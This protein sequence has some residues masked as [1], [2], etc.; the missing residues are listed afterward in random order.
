MQVR[1]EADYGSEEQNAESRNY[2]LK[3][4]RDG[5]ASAADILIG[6][7]GEVSAESKD[8]IESARK[9]YD[10][11]TEEQKASVKN[12]GLLSAAEIDYVKVLI[13]AIGT[14]HGN[15]RKDINKA[16]E[17]YN[18]LLPEQQT[19]VQSSDGGRHSSV[20]SS[21]NRL[22]RCREGTNLLCWGRGVPYYNG[23]YK[24]RGGNLFLPME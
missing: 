13:D 10:A 18:A 9:A 15:S 17:A 11:L 23:A 14:V 21:N 19:G 12:Y 2:I 22:P 5:A 16:R 20:L 6:K 3:K 1:I 7:I 24:A 8:A 4:V